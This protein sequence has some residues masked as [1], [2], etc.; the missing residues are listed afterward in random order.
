VIKNI[1]NIN[2]QSL[3]S[4]LKFLEEP[5]GDIYAI[6]T[7]KNI[8]NV[9]PTIKS[10]CQY[11]QMPTNYSIEKK[12][13]ALQLTLYDDYDTLVND[14]DSGL[15]DKLFKFANNL[16]NTTNIAEIKSL[17]D[18]FKKMEYY[19]ITIILKIIFYYTKK[20]CL[21]EFIDKIYLNP[22]KILLFN[23]VFNCTRKL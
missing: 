20:E 14:I 11:Y 18:Q 10:R 22:N 8:N 19:E 21:L 7:C 23:Q 13:D 5:H 15:Y 6:F 17:S 12:Y 9:L 3:N 16:I 4:L 2:A 1:E